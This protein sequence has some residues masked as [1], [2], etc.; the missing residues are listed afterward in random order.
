MKTR[1]IVCR[2]LAA[3]VLVFGLGTPAQ[4]ALQAVGPVSAANGFPVWYEDTNNLRLDLCLDQNGFCLTEEPN[5]ALPISFPDNFGPEAFWWAGEAAVTNAGINGLLVLAMEAA[6]VNED[7]IP[8]D[9]V[10]FARIRIR[11]D[12][13]V[14]GSYTVTH[15]Y[16]VITFPNVTVAAGI[17]VT[18]DIGNFLTPGPLG[19]FTVALGDDPAQAGTVNADGRSIG[20]FLT[21]ADGLTFA[22]PLTG[23]RYISSPLA[24]TTVTGSPFL[25]NF[26]RIEGPGGIVAETAAFTLMGKISGCTAAN[27]A[28]TALND[29]AATAAGVPVIINVLA[30]DSDVVVDVDGAGVETT[31]VISPPLGTVRVVAGSIAP[32]GSGIATANADGTITFTP[33]ANALGT[34]TFRYIVQDLCGLDSL[35]ATVAVL[36]EDLVF[37]K[38]EYRVRTGKFTLEGSS[39]LRDLVAVAGT[40]TAYGTGLFGAQEVPPR[41]SAASGDFLAIFD[42]TV[43]PAVAFDY[44]LTI[45]V[46]L[47]VNI[48]QAHIH[49]GDTGV[50]GPIIFFLCTNL[51]NAPVGT[52]VPLCENVNG[53]ISASGTLTAAELQA[54]G[55]ITTFDQAVTALQSGGT[56]V[57]AHS[58]VFPAGEIR[59]QIGRNVISLR[60]GTTGPAIGAAEVQIDNS[61][62]FTGKSSASPGAAPHP[63]RAESGLSIGETRNLRLR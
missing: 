35:E 27:E 2:L 31:R 46:P 50:N 28:P 29:F 6:F 17:N 8:G 41:T 43:T 36:V 33:A 22:D 23:N 38:A 24:P 51:G 63:I 19:D 40:E 13:P 10:A 62:A 11:V 42:N 5:P 32:A 44:D 12:V 30:N 39:N 25:T 59:G 3:A 14:D 21:R 15:P 20:P 52:I 1:T 16:G 58:V 7:P 57:N 61:W 4:S 60:S 9:Q 49:V 56:Y 18:Q 26:F 45:N 34:V 47:G 55:G 37:G 53:V 48:T 54:A